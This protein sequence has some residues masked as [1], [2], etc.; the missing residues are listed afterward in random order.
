MADELAI[1]PGAS[2]CVVSRTERELVLEARYAGGG[3]PPP[4]HFHPA[5]DERFEVLAGA[6]RARVDG[7]ESELD[8]GD[9]LEVPRGTAHQFWNPGEEEAAVRWITVPAGRTLE[10]FRELAAATSGS[11]EGDPATLL[12]RFADT[13]RLAGA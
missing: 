3:S 4:A 13:F 8:V 9:V 12:E 6:I 10:F 7:K 11:A 5:Q 1:S 2:L